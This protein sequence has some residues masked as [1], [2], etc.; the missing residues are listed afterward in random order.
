MLKKRP[1]VVRAEQEV[2]C[3]EKLRQIK[4]N[5]LAHLIN[6]FLCSSKITADLNMKRCYGCV[7]YSSAL[8][9]AEVKTIQHEKCE[10]CA[11]YKHYLKKLEHFTIAS[12]VFYSCNIST[13]TYT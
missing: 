13:G 3:T 9:V 11:H 12:P 4:N 5:K 8:L 1:V 10:L 7:H 6:F 2:N